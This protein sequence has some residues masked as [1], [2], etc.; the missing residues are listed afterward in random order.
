V[1][2]PSS[3]AVLHREP[4]VADALASALARYPSLLPA[5]VSSDV[6]ALDGREFDAVALDGS[7]PGASAAA[8]ALRRRG[9][10]VIVMRGTATTGTTDTAD[11]AAP[12]PG[13]VAALAEA[14]EPH[15]CDSDGQVDRLSRREREVLTLAAKGLAG[16]QIA[17]R[18]G[19]SPKTVEAH[20]SKIFTKLRV[21]SQT[22]AVAMMTSVAGGVRWTP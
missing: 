6:A 9:V 12:P 2:G 19:I 18:L 10:R 15:A 3:V 5:L 1:R 4:L 16:K 22:A 20:K 7:L 11:D 17:A 21:R 8:S 14:L 13:S